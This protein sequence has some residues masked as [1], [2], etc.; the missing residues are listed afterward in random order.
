MAEREVTDVLAEA[1][2]AE[3]VLRAREDPSGPP[4]KTLYERHRTDVFRYLLRIV[5]ERD[6]AEDLVQDTF[7][8]IY[9]HLGRFDAT[10]AFRPW[11]YQIAR[12]VALNALRARRLKEK[13]SGDLPERAASDRVAVQVET[14][15]AVTKA[16]AALAAL[17]DEE[18]A[19]L[20]ERVG[21]GLKMSEL[22]ESLGVTER[23]V[24]NRLDA[25]IDRLTRAFLG[26]KGGA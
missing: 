23:T 1:P 11:L 6:L 25:A 19:L 18:R 14:G 9:E 17:D 15:D 7:L 10:R 22:A 16:R 4:F 8:R 24:R 3:L 5:A 12:N 2:D 13:A 21:L 20:V 26:T